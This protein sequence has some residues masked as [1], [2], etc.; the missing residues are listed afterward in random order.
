MS[1]ISTPQDYFII[2]IDP[3]TQVCEALRATLDYWGFQ[4]LPVNTI[5]EAEHQM[6]IHNFI[7][8]VVII[9]LPLSE[10][11]GDISFVMG[12]E[13]FLERCDLSIPVI[14]MTGNADDQ[15]RA[16]VE[17]KGWAYL[18]KPFTANA[19]FSA[20]TAIAGWRVH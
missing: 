2:V 17:D 4:V 8:H 3:H 6:Q 19:L 1:V 16:A 5:R 14:T 7:P 15:Y 12:I 18:L 10:A 13:E 11:E 20:L 9:D